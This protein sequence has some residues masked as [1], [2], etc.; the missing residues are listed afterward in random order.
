MTLLL[1]NFQLQAQ[2]VNYDRPILYPRKAK[3]PE[4]PIDYQINL[5]SDIAVAIVFDEFSIFLK[6][7]EAEF[8]EKVIK[9]V[10][11]DTFIRYVGFFKCSK[12]NQQYQ[13]NQL[14]VLII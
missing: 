8:I 5:E 10:K 14:L 1:I 3:F 13:Q 2:L 4:N 6:L 12:K 9:E 11:K 7:F